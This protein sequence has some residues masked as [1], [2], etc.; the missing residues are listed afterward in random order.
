MGGG[1]R[2]PLRFAPRLE[3]R[4]AGPGR[5][6]GPRQQAGDGDVRALRDADQGRLLEPANGDRRRQHHRAVPRQLRL[7]QDRHDHHGEL[8][9]E[10]PQGRHGRPLRRRRHGADPGRPV[11]RQAAVDLLFVDDGRQRQCRARTARCRLRFPRLAERPG[12]RPERRQRHGRHPDV[13]GDPPVAHVR[14]GGLRRPAG[15]AVPRRIRR[16]SRGRAAV[17]GRARRT[18]VHRGAATAAR[19]DP[20]RPGNRRGRPEYRR[21]RRGRHP[22]ARRNCRQQRL[23]RRRGGAAAGFQRNCRSACSASY[24]SSGSSGRAPG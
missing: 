15:D 18:G 2:P 23:R 24:V 3:R 4:R 5:Q 7:G 1:R 10:R 19:G 6:A 11:R 8:V 14:R 16:R 12:I 20:V 21:H 17:P 22:G 13:H 9:G